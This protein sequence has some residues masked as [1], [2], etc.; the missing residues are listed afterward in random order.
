MLLHCF[1]TYYLPIK[2]LLAKCLLDKCPR[3]KRSWTN[4]I[5]SGLSLMNFSILLLFLL[6]TLFI[7]GVVI[8]YWRHDTIHQHSA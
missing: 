2:C 3:T 6:M 1:L 5:C 8:P 4:G 7:E